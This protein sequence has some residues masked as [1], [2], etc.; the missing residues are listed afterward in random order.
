MDLTSGLKTSAHCTLFFI[1]NLSVWWS[2]RGQVWLWQLNSR[3]NETT[4]GGSKAKKVRVQLSLNFLGNKVCLRNLWTS[5]DVFG[6]P[7]A[8]G[9]SL[10]D[11]KTFFGCFWDREIGGSHFFCKLVT[12]LMI[13]SVIFN[14]VQRCS[15]LYHRNSCDRSWNWMPNWAASKRKSWSKLHVCSSILQ[16]MFYVINM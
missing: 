11:Q 4:R 1:E 6:C 3:K 14:D 9:L 8:H 10:I 7:S 5:F 2:W 13:C 15:V 16:N 12:V